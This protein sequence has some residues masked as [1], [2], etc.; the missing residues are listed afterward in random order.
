M[1]F[2]DVTQQQQHPSLIIIQACTCACPFRQTTKVHT[3]VGNHY[4][5]MPTLDHLGL[6]VVILVNGA[7]A[8]EYPDEE[9]GNVEDGFSEGIPRFYH[10]VES[11]NDAAFSVMLTAKLN[12]VNKWLAS[13]GQNPA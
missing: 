3:T 7:P 4:R 5:N 10:Y 11:Q 2:H 13:K 8:M 6:K 1:T 9:H 12:A